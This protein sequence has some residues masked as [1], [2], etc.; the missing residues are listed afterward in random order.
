MHPDDL[1]SPSDLSNYPFTTKLNLR[2]CYPFGMFAVPR[3][4]IKRIHASSGTTG[5]PTAMGY[6]KSDIE[7]WT[8]CVA[9][10][11]R[12]SGTRKGDLVRVA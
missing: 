2:D 10:S 3:D 8:G 6:A 5:K 12:A 1:N 4:Q 7:V 9:R 11:V